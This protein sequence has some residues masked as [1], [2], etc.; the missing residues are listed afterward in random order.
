MALPDITPVNRGRIEENTPIVVVTRYAKSRPDTMLL[1]L[2]TVVAT[3]T[4]EATPEAEEEIS[5]IKGATTENK[6]HLKGDQVGQTI[7][8]AEKMAGEIALEYMKKTG[9]PLRFIDVI[10]LL[11]DFHERTAQVFKLCVSFRPNQSKIYKG[12]ESLGI[13][14][15]LNRVVCLLLDFS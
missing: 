10:S 8:G 15:A 12:N 13:S 11:M 5:S 1:K 4:P 14:D 7:A 3:P 9:E 2:A 6:L